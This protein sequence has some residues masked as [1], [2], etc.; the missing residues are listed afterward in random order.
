MEEK[1]D[2]KI[3]IRSEEVQDILGQIPSWIVRW[4]TLVIL[5]TILVILVGSMF[6][7]Y[8]DI[9][10]AE[11]QVTTENPP[12][13]L[14][15]KI[16]G[17]IERFFVKDSQIVNIND[18]LAVIESAADYRDVFSLKFDIVEIGTIIANLDREE[19][20]P[21]HNTY[22]LGDI[23]STYAEFINVYDDYFQFLELDSHAKTIESK[24]EGKRRFKIYNDGLKNQVRILKDQ[25]VLAERQYNR[26]LK[27]HKDGYIA[28]LDIDKSEQIKLNAELKYQDFL[29]NM[30]SNEVELQKFEEHVLDLELKAQKEKEQKQID[31]REAFD[32]MI[33]QIAK[34]EQNFLLK[35]PID[36]SVSFIGFWSETQNVRKGDKVMTIIPSEPGEIIGRIDLPI[37]GSGKV[38]IGHRVNIQF[39]DYPH[40]EYG[41]VKGIIRSIS[42]VPNDKLYKVEVELPD[43]LT[44]YYN[45]EIPF[46]QEM[47]GRAEII[48]D[49][50]VL[51]ERIFSP[52]R[53]A[54]TEQR[55]TRKDAESNNQSE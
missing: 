50:R 30:S 27:L 35:A 9:K 12:A 39:T 42:Q 6:I 23:Q 16:D 49:D 32:K 54:I 45:F 40:L 26:D 19:G 28:D 44:T 18:A 52:I 2:Q 25:Y 47:L 55:E 3:E 20:I 10:R 46:K 5:A 51:I 53:S 24:K 33:A 17:Q 37:E 21:F 7:S 13:T 38:E 8:P 1:K 31:V 29:S 14:I 48:T 4:G 41:M 34:W 15:A 22:S 11:I 36:G 43:T